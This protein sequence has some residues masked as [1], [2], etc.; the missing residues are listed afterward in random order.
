MD[1]GEKRR[2]DGAGHWATVESESR[3]RQWKIVRDGIPCCFGPMLLWKASK[4][5]S[6]FQVRSQPSHGVE[7]I[8]VGAEEVRLMSLYSIEETQGI[9]CHT[10]RVEVTCLRFAAM[11]FRVDMV[12]VRAAGGERF[13]SSHKEV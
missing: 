11:L 6:G 8:E 4:G 1:G 7:G 13:C 5:T 3:L 12:E 10:C 2:A 9:N